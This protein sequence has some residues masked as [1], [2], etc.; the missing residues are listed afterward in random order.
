MAEK[1]NKTEKKASVP[2]GSDSGKSEGNGL[3]S[4]VKAFFTGLLIMAVVFSGVFYI[5]VNNNINGI[6]DRYRS[7][8]QNIPVLKLAL[9]EIPDPDDPKNF[10]GNELRKKYN[11]LR[12]E[13]DDALQII[14]AKLEI[15]ADLEKKLSE[16][17]K[18]NSDDQ[19]AKDV[20]DKERAD[21]EALKKTLEDDKKEFDK[22]VANADTKGFKTYFEKIDKENAA[23][24]YEKVLI[25]E[26]ADEKWKDYAKTYE[27]MEPESAAKI[28]ENYGSGK[29]GDIVDI[30]YAMNRNSVAEILQAMDTVFAAKVSDNLAERYKLVE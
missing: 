3:I 19:A 16:A 29:M 17:E 8:I 1:L 30:L 14:D 6:A 13:R 11:E 28:L 22:L 25:V 10:T 21:I 24:I 23:A 20:L 15:I 7:E 27:N 9:P 12:K 5:I 2:Q 18:L 26:Q 4:V